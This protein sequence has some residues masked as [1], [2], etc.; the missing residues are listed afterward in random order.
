MPLEKNLSMLFEKRKKYAG[1]M[2]QRSQNKI[3]K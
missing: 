2:T 3:S 1:E